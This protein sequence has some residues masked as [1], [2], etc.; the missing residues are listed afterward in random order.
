MFFCVGNF[1]SIIVIRSFLLVILFFLLQLAA[2]RNE[3]E[4]R[5]RNSVKEGCTVST[6]VRLF[7][8]F[9]VNICI[10]F[11]SILQLGDCDESNLHILRILQY[12]KCIW[13]VKISLYN[14]TAFILALKVVL[15]I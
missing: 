10:C 4:I 1:S 2:L 13:T 7:K 8:Y 15:P 11:G 12:T 14:I 9:M 5:M 6:E 3:I